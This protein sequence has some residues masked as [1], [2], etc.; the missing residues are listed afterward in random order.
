MAAHETSAFICAFMTDLSIVGKNIA[1]DNFTAMLKILKDDLIEKKTFLKNE[2]D[3]IKDKI[4][5][6]DIYSKE[7]D[8]R[9][10]FY[11]LDVD[12][13]IKN[14]TIQKLKL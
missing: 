8:L 9:E 1:T 2:R 6:R 4:L 5:K 14:E 7:T 3:A 12:E 13:N 11:Y 10:L